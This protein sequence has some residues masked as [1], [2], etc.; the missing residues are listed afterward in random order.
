[1][2]R[3]GLTGGLGSGKTT[4]A[5]I[6]ASLGAHILSADEIARALMQ[7]GQ[8]VFAAIVKKFGAGV[9]RADGTLD[10]SE[11]SRL[12]FAGARVEELNAIVHPAAIARQEELAEEIA[13]RDPGAVVIVES[14]L[15]FE[16]RHSKGWRGRFDKLILVRATEE[17]KIARYVERMFAQGSNPEAVEADARLRLSKLIADDKKA[18]QCDFVILNDGTL[19]RLRGQVEKIWA[20]LKPA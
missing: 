8:P 10:R 6:F 20:K 13:Q 11:L 5:G 1:M 16:T 17:H 2:I 3:V 15:I 18:A 19:D 14:A 9:V 7:P 4:V 12:A